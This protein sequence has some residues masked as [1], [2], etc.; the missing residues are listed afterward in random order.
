[1]EPQRSPCRPQSSQRLAFFALSKCARAHLE[2]QRS[3][4]PAHPS[5]PHRSP[6][7]R[8]Q[9]RFLGLRM[10]C[11]TS[12]MRV[13]V[14]NGMICAPTPLSCARGTRKRFGGQRARFGSNPCGG[15]V[16]RAIRHGAKPGKASAWPWVLRIAPHCAKP[17]PRT[18]RVVQSMLGRAYEADP[19]LT[20]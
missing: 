19:A 7:G 9:L 10:L 12:A 13:Q 18:A 6:L 4:L 3:A 20:R 8:V 17:T 15:V 1:L 5:A 11:I 14:L 2:P 16:L